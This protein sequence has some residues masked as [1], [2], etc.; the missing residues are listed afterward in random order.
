[1]S[2]VERCAAVYIYFPLSDYDVSTGNS[3]PI[4]GRLFVFV[5]FMYQQTIPTSWKGL[6]C[7]T[8]GILG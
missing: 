1:M 4:H 8:M 3:N 6:Q 7:C 5:L 2:L